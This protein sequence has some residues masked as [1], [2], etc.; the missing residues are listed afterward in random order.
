MTLAGHK[1]SVQSVAISPDGKLLAS[2]ASTPEL[3]LWDVTSGK[4]VHTLTAERDL[5]RRVCFSP[6]GRWVA[7]E[8][9]ARNNG[10]SLGI[11]DVA[12]GKL[13]TKAAFGDGSYM[14]TPDSKK[15][16]FAGDAVRA[17]RKRLLLVLDIERQKVEHTTENGLLP[18]QLGIAALSPDGKVVALAGRVN[19]ADEEG[20]AI[21]SLW[22][23]AGDR[24]LY[25]LDQW[26][27]HLAFTP[28]GRTLLGVSRD[29][30]ARVWD[31]R[32]GTWRET[33]QVCE[34]GDFAINDIAVAPDSRH[35]A[36]AMG[37]GTARIFR[38]SPAPEQVEPREPLPVTNVRPEPPT[39]LWRR[40]IGKP[41]P[42]FREVKAWA[43]GSAVKIADLRG[44]FV[45]LHFWN[46]TSDLQMF[47]LV[48]LHEKFADQGLVIIAVQ[49][50]WG[51][52]TVE[53]WQT[54]ANRQREWGD[55]A[56]PFRI[57]L[58]GGGKT[59]IAQTGTVAP[60][61]T[62]A[63]FGVQNGRGGLALQPVNL[64]IGPDGRV[65]SG[66]DSP[67]SLERELEA[68]MGVKAKVPAWR[69]RFE[70]R[71]RARRRAGAQ[72]RRSTVSVRAGR[73]PARR[74]TPVAE[75]QGA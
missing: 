41:A 20:K 16:I 72:T 4:R 73:L 37:N 8:S 33:I 7:A 66:D 6:D 5:G 71:V 63:A 69:A 58:D 70:Q 30:K 28:D 26:A 25:Q 52:A 12:T 49:P 40:L 14:F 19:E 15:L 24:P 21:I 35:F 44:K 23:L 13:I 65:V 60:G 22:D 51:I 68:R 3:M 59:P 36:A 31:P 48:G 55:R 9:L 75:R 32:N 39:D 61:A 62:F 56:L 34:A 1:H 54:H 38:L 11:W 64:L 46:T 2:I 10:R 42:E 29:G 27:D 53:E 43:G 45:L 18:S 57:A 17:A 67:W 74:I 50:D 47:H